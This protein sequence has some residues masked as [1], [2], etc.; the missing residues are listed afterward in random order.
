MK[1]PPKEKAIKMR[2]EFDQYDD[3]AKDRVS[4]VCDRMISAFTDHKVRLEN[5]IKYWNDVKKENEEM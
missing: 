5:E 4:R 2:A 3:D 1:L